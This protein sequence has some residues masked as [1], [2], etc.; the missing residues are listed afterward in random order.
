MLIW[1]LVC[2]FFIRCSTDFVY[3]SVAIALALRRP[4]LGNHMFQRRLHLFLFV[5][6]SPNGRAD[7][8]MIPLCL[9]FCHHVNCMFNMFNMFP[10]LFLIHWIRRRA[11][12]CT[13]SN[14]ACQGEFRRVDRF[15][16]LP[17]QSGAISELWCF[18]RTPLLCVGKFFVSL[19]LEY[20]L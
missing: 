12:L 1:C 4:R 17:T 5:L 7:P 9:A 18:K 19:S 15:P 14:R 2:S 3:P 16:G 10:F 8:M 11:T 6:L 20:F 13:F